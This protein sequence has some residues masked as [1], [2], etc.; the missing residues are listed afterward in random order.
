MYVHTFNSYVRTYIYVCARVCRIHVHAF[1]YVR[2][3]VIS[4]YTQNLASF[5]LLIHMNVHTFYVCARMRHMPV[6][7]VIYMRECVICTYTQHWAS[8]DLRIYVCIRTLIHVRVFV[9]Y[10]YVKTTLF[11]FIVVCAAFT[12]LIC[13]FTC[14]YT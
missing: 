3:C 4:A 9:I 10:T 2:E 14:K 5:D 6:H 8:L 13:L 11:I 7:A 12:F 1:T